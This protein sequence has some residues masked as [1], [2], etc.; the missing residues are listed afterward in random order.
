M[1]SD[2]ILFTSTVSPMSKKCEQYIRENNLPV[3]FVRLDTKRDRMKAMKGTNVRIV[4]VPTLLVMYEDGNFQ[5]FPGIEQTLNWI[6]AASRQA[7]MD[8]KPYIESEESE[9]EV[10]VTPPKRKKNKGLYSGKRE[11]STPHE[12]VSAP[13]NFE[14]SDDSNSESEDVEITSI[15]PPV[16]NPLSTVN[17]GQTSPMQSLM[18]QVKEMEE[19]RQQ[20]LQNTFGY[21]EERLPQTNS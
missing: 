4:G 7:K 12:D 1:I 13:V 14:D 19:Q 2:V 9:E 18:Q 5:I 3:R 10:V 16:N 21:Q 8:K 17:A 20:H 11:K 15:V 6:Q